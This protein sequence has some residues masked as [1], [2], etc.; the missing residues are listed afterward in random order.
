MTE[1]NS[2]FC[3]VDITNDSYEQIYS[4]KILITELS[5]YFSDALNFFVHALDFSLSFPFKGEMSQYS[6]VLLGV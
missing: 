2:I 4:D 3:H 5:S 6:L 1:K